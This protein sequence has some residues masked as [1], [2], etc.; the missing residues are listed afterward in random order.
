MEKF[1]RLFKRAIPF[2]MNI[3]LEDFVKEYIC[4]EQDIHIEDMQEGAMLYGRMCRKIEATMQEIEELKQISAQYQVMEEKKKRTVKLPLPDGQTDD[5]TVRA[6]HRGNA[7]ACGELEKG[8]RT[9]ERKSRRT[10]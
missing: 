10:A 8:C 2:K 4:M 7:A 9:A 6:D 5:L 1:P 3:R